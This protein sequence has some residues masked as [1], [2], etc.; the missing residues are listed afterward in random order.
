MARS[1]IY[2]NAISNRL[3]ASSPR[4]SVLGMYVGTAIS[5]L[6]DPADKRMKF[7]SEEL[8]NAEGQRYVNLKGIRDTIGSIEDLKPKKVASKQMV[9]RN[10]ESSAAQQVQ[11]PL[12]NSQHS[13]GSR[14]ISIEEVETESG[15][16]K[17]DDLPTY[18][19][20]DSD[21]SDSDD[22]PTVINR[23]KPTAPV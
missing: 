19:K 12:N 4:L 7:T 11:Q 1:S 3:A 18:A 21:A 23:D 22:D 15:S 17:G 8:K 20:P 14:I 16:E 9:V 13:K 10:A 6:V 5:E 2:L